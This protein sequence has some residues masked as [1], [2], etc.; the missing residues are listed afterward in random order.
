VCIPAVRI[1]TVGMRGGEAGWAEM[2]RGM[3]GLKEG[4][5]HQEG[6]PVKR[7]GRLGVMPG[8]DVGAGRGIV[9]RIER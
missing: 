4:E 5:D 8:S 7:T 9:W 1:P 3:N 2:R 6:E